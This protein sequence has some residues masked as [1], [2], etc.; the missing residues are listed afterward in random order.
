MPAICG[1]IINDSLARPHFVI[2]INKGYFVKPLQVLR[3]VS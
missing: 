1:V 2:K 3:P